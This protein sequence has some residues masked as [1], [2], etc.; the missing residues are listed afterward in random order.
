MPLV[1]VS[2]LVDRLTWPTFSAVRVLDVLR[3]LVKNARAAN[4]F[5][6]GPLLDWPDLRKLGSEVF[7]VTAVSSISGHHLAWGLCANTPSATLNT[8]FTVVY[9]DS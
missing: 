2:F 7:K 6:N 9:R 3:T 5:L 8:I 1:L 4:R